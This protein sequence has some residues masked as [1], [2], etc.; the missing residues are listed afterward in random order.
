EFRRVVFRSEGQA[1]VW[2]AG[3]QPRPA[4]GGPL[5][6]GARA[7]EA[8]TPPGGRAPAG[9]PG[10]VGRPMLSLTLASLMDEVHAHSGAVYLL[11]PDQPVLEMAVTAGRTRAFA[12]P[13]EGDGV[14][15]SHVG[16]TAGRG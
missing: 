1:A 5:L 15:A 16:R 4:A 2:P 8:G 13:W 11:A 10:P 9:A 12:A 7:P 6:R 3:E 14:G